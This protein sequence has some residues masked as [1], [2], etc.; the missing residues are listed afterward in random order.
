MSQK[1]IIIYE[2]NILFSILNEINKF[3]NF[4][5]ISANKDNFDK[6]KKEIVSD[7]LVISNNDKIITEN[8]IILKNL[9]LKIEKL[10]ETINLNFLKNKYDLQ[11]DLVIGPYKINLNSRQILKRN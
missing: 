1:K 9:P 2:F 11:S 8:L 6:I 10:V 7:F 3:L 5:I 4:N